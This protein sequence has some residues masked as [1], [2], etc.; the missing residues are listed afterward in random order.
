MIVCVCYLTSLVEGASHS[1]ILL[2][3]SKREYMAGLS[4]LILLL[5]YPFSRNV[6]TS[7]GKKMI[8]KVRLGKLGK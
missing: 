2:L 6:F 8:Y 7:K 5:R 3:A 1:I 4:S